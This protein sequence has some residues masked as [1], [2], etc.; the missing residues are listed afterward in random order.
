MFWKV[1][2]SLAL[3][4]ML[5]LLLSTSTPSQT[6]IAAN[7]QNILPILKITI[8]KSGI[9][10]LT[11]EDLMQNGQSVYNVDPSSF[12]LMHRDEKVAY[13]VDGDGDAHFE[14]T[15]RILFYGLAFDGSQYEKQFVDHNVYWFWAWDSS[16]SP[17]GRP[18]TPTFTNPPIKTSTTTQTFAEEND[19]F[20]GWTDRWDAF[21]NPPDAWYWDRL[22]KIGFGADGL[23]QQY[24]LPIEA[25]AGSGQITLTTE[26]MS[27]AKSPNPAQIESTVKV[28]LNNSAKQSLS[29]NGRQNINLTQTLAA[30]HLQTDGNQLNISVTTPDVLY[31][32]RAT[33]TYTQRLVLTNHPLFFINDK[34]Q[35]LLVETEETAVSNLLLWDVTNQHQPTPILL[36]EAH[37]TG[38]GLR[39][40]QENNSHTSYLLTTYDQLLT[41]TQLSIYYPEY[42]TPYSQQAEWLVITHHSL[43][44]AASRLA[45][46]RQQQ[47]MTTHLVDIEDVINMFGDGFATP[48]AVN[49]YLKSTQTWQ[50][51]PRYV[52]LMGDGS[53]NPRQLS[54][55]WSCPVWDETEPNLIPTDLQFVDR[56]QGLIPTDQ[57]MG[58]LDDDLL[59]DVIMGRISAR[60]LAEANAAVSKII[61]YETA[62]SPST[63]F[64]K[65]VLFLADN[66]DAAGDFCLQNQLTANLLPAS[67]TIQS[68]CLPTNPTTNQV[69]M[70]RQAVHEQIN[71]TGAYVL[72]YRGHGSIQSWGGGDEILLS[73]AETHSTLG[74]WR[75]AIPTVIVSADCLDGHFAWPGLRS[76]SE[77]LLTLE[78]SG[79]AAHWSSSGLGSDSEHAQMH[80]GFYKALAAGDASRLGD[81]ILEAQKSYLATGLPIPPLYSFT[82]QGDPALKFDWVHYST[83]FLP[84]VQS[85]N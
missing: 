6:A 79:T 47:G 10:V 61:D 64:D 42:L 39:I 74:D 82:L 22:P 49:A 18:N 81:A 26:W 62:V 2:S 4:S 34:R 57:T 66:T 20:S 12:T 8:E 30:S 15:E 76:I 58:M 52:L 67:V 69:A 65:S 75:N 38:S 14:P 3:M 33:I 32:N 9:Y 25:P 41:P 44:E 13:Q 73:V 84:T 11:F 50:T 68:Y 37:L 29:W 56:F 70:I 45:Q 46:Y 48:T 77:S 83:L 63:H 35:D 19:F 1:K 28:G 31:L 60:T 27:R 54:C 59:P 17:N 24:P 23:T 40:G 80:Q 36:E 51:P 16:G 43:K 53:L 78:G 85:K 71:N 72:N 7:R 55:Q 21:P 5:L